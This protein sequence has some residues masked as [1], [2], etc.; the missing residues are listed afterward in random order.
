MTGLEIDLCHGFVTCVWWLWS[1]KCDWRFIFERRPR[2]FHKQFMQIGWMDSDIRNLTAK[3]WAN[4]DNPIKSYDF[5]MFWLICCVL[6]ISSGTL[7]QSVMSQQYNCLLELYTNFTK[8]YFLWKYI[9]SL[10][11][12]TYMYM[13]CRYVIELGW[14]CMHL[15]LNL[16]NQTI[17][18]QEKRKK[19]KKK[20]KI[21][22]QSQWKVVLLWYHRFWQSSSRE[23]D[24]QN[25]S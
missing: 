13:Y 21:Y 1:G 6:R 15:W 16:V 14:S 22:V 17:D 18:I 3:V 23:G 19:K 10:Y 20:M 7:L 8:F 11:F 9:S 4:L 25:F 24:I 5:S 2:S 12:Y